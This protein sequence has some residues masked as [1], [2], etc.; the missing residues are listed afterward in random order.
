[1]SQAKHTEFAM[2]A[3]GLA[4][5]FTMMIG[6]KPLKGA[7]VYTVELGTPDGPS[8]GGGKQA[9]QPIKLVPEGG[10]PTLVAGHANQVEKSAELRSYAL[11]QQQH[12]ARFRGAELQVDQPEYDELL[13][14]LTNFFAQQGLKVTTA[15]AEVLEEPPVSLPGNPFA[16][17]L[18][19]AVAGMA[20]LGA[21]IFFLV[22]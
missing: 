11:V 9:L 13:T 7:R 6:S 16:S 15:Q 17:R 19:L 4:E 3:L 12:D 8:T 1:M 14:R 21:A 20:V 22:R 2:K 18:P 5:L 10:G